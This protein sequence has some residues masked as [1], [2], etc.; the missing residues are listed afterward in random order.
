MG[1]YPKKAYLIGRDW[2]NKCEKEYGVDNDTL[3]YFSGRAN[4]TID[5]MITNWHEATTVL[6]KYLIP[7]L[8]KM[9]LEYNWNDRIEVRDEHNAIADYK[10]VETMSK[11]INHYSGFSHPPYIRSPRPGDIN[12]GTFMCSYMKT[13][14]PGEMERE[15]EWYENLF[16][17]TLISMKVTNA[18]NYMGM[19]MLHISTLDNTDAN[20]SADISSENCSNNFAGNGVGNLH[21]IS[22]A[23]TGIKFGFPGFR[24][25]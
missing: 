20:F 15:K 2:D 5:E 4:D 19:N 16:A 24:F 7:D 10:A 23:Y 17:N 11:W 22:E 14:S 13:L 6:D 12:F 9:V 3:C 8:S 25:F 21:E 18:A 1:N